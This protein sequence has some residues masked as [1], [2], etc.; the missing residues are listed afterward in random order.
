MEARPDLLHRILFVR[1]EELGAVE[2]WS[3]MLRVLIAS[4]SRW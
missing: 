2:L 1:D 4:R 3:A